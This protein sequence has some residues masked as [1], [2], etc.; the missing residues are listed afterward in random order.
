VI[1]VLP[2]GAAFLPDISEEQLRALCRREKLR[3]PQ[4]RLLAALRRKQGWTLKR[5]AASLEQPLMT[6]HGWLTRLQRRGIEG[7]HDRKQTGRPAHLTLEQKRQFIKD[8]ERGPPHN[9]SGLWT[10]KLVQ[11]L[12]RRKY[13]VSFVKQHVWRMLDQLGFALLRPRKQHHRRADAATIAAFKKK[14]DDWCANTG[15]VAMS[16][17]LKTKQLSA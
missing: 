11:D 6:I 14:R 15:G 12:L 9:H 3:K 16:L 5:I 2:K 13:N 4:L 7:L 1:H 17:P 8:L 10:T